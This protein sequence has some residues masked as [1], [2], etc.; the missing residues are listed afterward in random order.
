MPLY[1]FTSKEGETIEEFF[2]MGKSPEALFR[3]RRKDDLYKR[4][5]KF[6]RD[7]AAE[8]SGGPAS[9]D[10]GEWPIECY[11]SGVHASQA[12]ELREHFK[13]HGCPTEVTNDGDPIYRDH[14][15]R[16]R[17]LKCR[18]LHDRASFGN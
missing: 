14:Q 7:R 3:W 5:V 9:G 6:F 11:A 12:Q 2:R 1:C 16:K 4:K 8:W 15:H 18:G 13:S 17:A 10:K